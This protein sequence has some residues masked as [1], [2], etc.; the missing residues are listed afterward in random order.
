MCFN[1]HPQ[2]SEWLMKSKAITCYKIVRVKRTD[3]K[4]YKNKGIK[5][6]HRRFSYKLNRRYDV[7]DFGISINKE[8]IYQGFHSYIT[9]KAAKAVLKSYYYYRHHPFVLM[10]C[11]IP[12]RTKYYFNPHLYEYV[13]LALI[14]KELVKCIK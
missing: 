5:S 11:S 4:P 3:G 8:Y 12:P 1:I 9:L 10:K 6:Q 14:T 2:H 7:N 13:S